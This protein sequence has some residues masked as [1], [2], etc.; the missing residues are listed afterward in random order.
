MATLRAAGLTYR[1]IGDRMGVS[2]QCVQQALRHSDAAKLVPVHCRECGT[3]ITRMRTAH[4]NDGQ[5]YCLDCLPTDARFSE[6]LRAYRL[7]AQ[8]TQ[9][10]LAAQVSVPPAMIH[11]WERSPGKPSPPN[12]AALVR[13]FGAGLKGVTPRTSRTRLSAVPRR[14]LRKR[15]TGESA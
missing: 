3:V 15:L 8:L 14:A 5:V 7:A 2:R 9:A 12:V 1:Q 6:R 11:G 10:E 4:N 13:F